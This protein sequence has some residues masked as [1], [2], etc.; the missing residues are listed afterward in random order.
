MKFTRKLS[1]IALAL[2]T[3]GSVSSIANAQCNPLPGTT[4]GDPNGDGVRSNVQDVVALVN[5]AFRGQ[6]SSRFLGS[7]DINGDG[8]INVQDVVGIVNIAFRG[9]IPATPFRIYSLTGRSGVG[10]YTLIA[11]DSIQY[12][13]FG[14]YEVGED[15]ADLGTSSTGKTDTLRVQAGTDIE[16]DTSTAT[17]AAL[18]IRRTGY[19]HFVGTSSD[20]V[21]ITSMLAD[22]ARDRGDW[23][24]MVING[25]APNNNAPT[26][27]FQA[28][29]NG[30]LG[31][32]TDA[33]DNSGCFKYL[34]VE[35]AGREFT[36]D[37]ELNGITFNGVGDGTTVEYV[38][39]NQNA[40]DGFEW[41]GGRVNVKH[42]VFSG[43]DD[44]GFDSDLG[45]QWKG[46]FLITVQDPTKTSSSNPNGNEWDNHPTTSFGDSLP[47]MTPTVWN[48]TVIGQRADFATSQ[49]AGNHVRKG[50]GCD[51]NN[52]V[53]TKFRTALDIDN[54]PPADSLI[55]N[56]ILSIRNSVWY[57]YRFF[58]DG[59]S[60][61]LENRFRDSVVFANQSF[62]NATPA[63]PMAEIFVE[64]N[65]GDVGFPDFRPISGGNPIGL[66][67]QVGGT[68]PND[69]FF[70]ATATFKGAI[71]AT[72]ASPWWLGWTDFSQF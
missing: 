23:G 43:T 57:D 53:W 54:N 14:I 72:D 17:P 12:R 20:P 46:Q 44:D 7:D 18:V 37:N 34:R 2:L 36:T 38:Q 67:T 62:V 60:L 66:D 22:G 24:G 65:Y 3:A 48:M 55:D 56:G 27:L 8:V 9:S 45:A 10:A 31:G 41:F 59:D 40:D 52:T 71:S 4:I 33:N 21:V 70:D 1:A 64:V 28:E 61:A 32:G 39:V 30:G 5:T 42:I 50:A 13:F 58:G 69:G 15:R 47:R 35:F 19:G 51:I 68:P 25:F 11:D 6:S 63:V 49:N 16:G 29:G 26:Y